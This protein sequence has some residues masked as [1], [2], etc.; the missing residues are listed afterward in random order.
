M[1][2]ITGRLLQPEQTLFSVHNQNK[3]LEKL[4]ERAETGVW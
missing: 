1:R 3:K 2:K 4:M